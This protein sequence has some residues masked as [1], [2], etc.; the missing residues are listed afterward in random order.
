MNKIHLECAE[1]G[2]YVGKGITWH[3]RDEGYSICSE[4]VE[5]YV[6]DPKV[7]LDLYGK[8]FINRPPT[9]LELKEQQ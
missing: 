7:L 8:P 9:S 3:N 2:N 4:C 5:D 1:C 6:D